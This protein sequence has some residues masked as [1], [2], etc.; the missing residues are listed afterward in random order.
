LR[1]V[2]LQHGSN[3]ARQNEHVKKACILQQ[4]WR[5]ISGP[6]SIG[7]FCWATTNA[8]SIGNPSSSTIPIAS[9]NRIGGRMSVHSFSISVS[10]IVVVATLA[11]SGRLITV[12]GNGNENDKNHS[13]SH[14]EYECDS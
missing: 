12:D 11:I 6:S 3:D 14:D 8:D 2:T 5:S 7:F 10:I 13:C 4:Q 9:A 1:R